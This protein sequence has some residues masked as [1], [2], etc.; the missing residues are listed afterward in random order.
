MTTY[1]NQYTIEEEIPSDSDNEDNNRIDNEHFIFK[2]YTETF[3]NVDKNADKNAEIITYFKNKLINED[4]NIY[5]LEKISSV[6]NELNTIDK[7]LYNNTSLLNNIESSNEINNVNMILSKISTNKYLFYI[8][9]SDESFNIN[10]KNADNNLY[11]L[12]IDKDKVDF[13]TIYNIKQGY[14]INSLKYIIFLGNLNKDIDGSKIFKYDKVFF[15]SYIIHNTEDGGDGENIQKIFSGYNNIDINKIIF[16]LYH[17]DFITFT[18]KDFKKILDGLKSSET[19]Q[20][21]SLSGGNKEIDEVNSSVLIDSVKDVKE[22]VKIG[23]DKVVKK[24]VKNKLPKKG[25]KST[26][27]ADIES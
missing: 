1:N 9:F 26:K 27:I 7:I 21:R 14:N 17:I 15:I 25:K 4:N 18:D 23:G 6:N 2:N 24:K 20:K 16:C 11:R 10:F 13:S 22:D 3:L 12:N 5:I 19:I 8:K